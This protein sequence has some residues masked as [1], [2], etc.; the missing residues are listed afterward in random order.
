MKSTK[1]VFI[2]AAC[3]LA[4]VL[5][6]SSFSL[7]QAQSKFNSVSATGSNG[8]IHFVKVQDGMLVFELNLENLPLKG[9][10][11]LI[12]DESGY[13]LFEQDI[14]TETFKIRYK[15]ERNQISKITFEVTGKKILFN[16]S[17]RI[18]SRMEERIEVAKL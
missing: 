12:K 11:L 17:F 1:S 6:S 9:S 2:K 15:I 14:K 8:D 3:M 10:R 5:F 4:F 16:K 18:S 7:S 13:L